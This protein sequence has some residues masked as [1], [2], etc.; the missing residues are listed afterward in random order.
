MT[1]NLAKGA[2]WES[3]ALAVLE[4][5]GR[6]V[7]PDAVVN[8]LALGLSVAPAPEAYGAVIGDVILVSPELSPHA[9][10]R[11]VTHGIARWALKKH[12]MPREDA[13]VV[14]VAEHIERTPAGHG[15]AKVIDLSAARL[16]SGRRLR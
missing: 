16:G 15:L 12:G 3:V 6:P 9:M 14:A 5:L 2:A 13:A 8:A 7:S 10:R 11:A 1:N 4:L